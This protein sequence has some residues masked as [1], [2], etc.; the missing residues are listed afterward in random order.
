MCKEHTG[1]AG[2]VCFS[3]VFPNLEVIPSQGVMKSEGW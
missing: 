1:V 2:T 3:P